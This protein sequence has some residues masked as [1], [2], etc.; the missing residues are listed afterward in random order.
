MNHLWFFYAIWVTTN[1]SGICI[2][3]IISGVSF[4]LSVEQVTPPTATKFHKFSSVCTVRLPSG[5]YF[6]L[7]ENTFSS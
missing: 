4:L 3:K 1:Y 2:A 7:N 5:S 6:F